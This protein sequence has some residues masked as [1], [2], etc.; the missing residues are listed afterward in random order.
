MPYN[1]TVYTAAHHIRTVL[2]VATVL[3]IKIIIK[4]I[5]KYIYEL[6]NVYSQNSKIAKLDAVFYALRKSNAVIRYVHMYRQ[7]GRFTCIWQSDANSQQK[8]AKQR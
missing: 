2:K 1:Y 8:V 5:Q 4:N 7:L 6:R 3:Y